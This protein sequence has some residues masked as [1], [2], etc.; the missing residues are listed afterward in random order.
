MYRP[1]LGQTGTLIFDIFV[2]LLEFM[3]I[4]FGFYAIMH[5]SSAPLIEAENDSELENRLMVNLAIET[6][7]YVVVA[8]SLFV[9]VFLLRSGVRRFIITNE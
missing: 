5:T 9:I 2:E 4:T 1:M 7:A 8:M 3:S 6:R